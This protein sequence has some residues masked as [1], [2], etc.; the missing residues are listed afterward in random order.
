[1]K[2][3]EKHGKLPELLS[4]WPKGAVAVQSWLEKQGISR[5][6]ADRYCRSHWLRRIG[7]GAYARLNESVEWTGAL[8]AVQKQLGL[9]IHGG[10]KT[11]LQLQGYGH[12]LPV[13]QGEVVSLFGPPRR[14]LPAWFA[15]RDWGVK[16]RH[17]ATNLFQNGPE[18][19]LTPKD[20]SGYSILLSAPERAILEFLDQVPRE[21]SFDEA[22]LLMEGLTTLRPQLVQGLLEACR[23]VKAKRLFLLLAELCEHSWAAKLDLKRVNL[24]KGK[25]MLAKHGHLDPKYLITVPF[26]RRE[27]ERTAT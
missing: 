9:P 26:R 18:E 21:E 8:Y 6:L 3:P 19:G 5:Q 15:R 23:S 16:V 7:R 25:R 27:Q 12:Y 22:K 20:M 14:R 4:T 11:A 1:M 10:G 13:G 24:G 2:N 17:T